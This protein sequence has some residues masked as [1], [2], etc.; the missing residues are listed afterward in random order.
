[1]VEYLSRN[2]AL[3]VARRTRTNLEFI[4]EARRKKEDVHEV[5]QLYISLLGLVVL[6]WQ[7]L[8]DQS[9]WG[10]NLDA[11]AGQGWPKW[12]ITCGK[13]ETKTLKHLVRHIRNAA[14]HGHITFSS[15]SPSLS[16][17]NIV[18]KDRRNQKEPFNWVAEITGEELYSFCLRFTEY[19]HSKL[20]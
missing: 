18:M 1:M 20:G 11:L 17:V 10:V 19:I 9:F 3:G 12:R 6:P 15:E 13:D 4:R 5:T 8:T 7:R 2:T 14:S 16:E